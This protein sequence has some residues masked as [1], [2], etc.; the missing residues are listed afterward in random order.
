MLTRRVCILGTGWWSAPWPSWDE[1]AAALRGGDSTTSASTPPG[2]AAAANPRPAPQ[3]LSANEHRR[4]PETVL[5]ALHA[6]EAA[7]AAAGVAPH[8]LPSVFATAHAD[9]AIVDALCQT[10]ARDPLQLSPMR[11]HHSVHNAASGYWAIA[12][13]ARAP[14]TALS[15][16]G[17]SFA[18]GLLE[19]ACQCEA[20][21]RPVLLAGFDTDARG[22]LASVNRSRGLLGV[23]L[24]LAPAA[25]AHSLCAID[26]CV[27]GGSTTLPPLQSAAAQA[28]AANAMA[29]ALPL[30][31]LLA[32][33]APA[34]T[35]APV[36]T[37]LAL[38]LGPAG[39]LHLSMTA[40]AAAS[41]NPAAA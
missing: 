7:C 29:D 30:F 2:T 26:W 18:G 6:A 34:P 9:L 20:D 13:G 27:R 39:T 35:S 17:A 38:P 5:M 3:L 19:A 36:P 1:A 23:A 12:A 16:H 21:Q 28:L 32:R 25:S 8:S 41:D 40:L 14:S 24:V 33:A 10:L 11:F 37:T 15:A 22:P 31:E 4:A